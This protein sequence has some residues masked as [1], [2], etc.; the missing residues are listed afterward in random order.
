MLAGTQ[1][2]KGVELSATGSVTRSLRVL[3]SYTFI[4]ARI[5]KSN[6]PAEVGKFFQNTPRHSVSVWATYTKEKF[7]LGLGP[8]FM[9]QR[10]GNNT[11]TRVVDAYWTMDAMAGFTVNKHLDLR[12]NLTNLNNAYYFDRLGGGHVIPGASRGVLM[13]TNFRF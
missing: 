3:G 4:D 11:N 7:S 2:S 8:R 12:L 10:F 13:T 9:G 1:V 6:T 5:G